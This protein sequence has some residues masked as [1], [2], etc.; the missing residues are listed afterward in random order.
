MEFLNSIS[1]IPFY[2]LALV[3][4]LT[5]LG[6]LFNPNLVRAGFL[7]I[8]SLAG[9]AGIYFMLS[10]NFVAIS[11]ILIYAVGITLVIV[12]AIMLCSL[13]DEAGKL[14]PDED[15]PPATPRKILAG[16]AS[17]ASF[18]LLSYVIFSQDWSRISAASY[19]DIHQKVI[20]E[21]SSQYT[22]NIGRLMM[23]DYILPFELVSVLLLVVLLGVVILSKKKI[24]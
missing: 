12:F 2:L 22:A 21:I 4:V 11:Q 5:S 9:I 16:I 7:L 3:I 15:T 13:K 10:A 14:V 17:I 6:M 24:D 18:V 20:P 19:G 23:S 8:A 1:Y